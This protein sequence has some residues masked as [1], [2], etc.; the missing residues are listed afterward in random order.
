MKGYFRAPGAI[1]AA[2]LFM[3]DASAADA[4]IPFAEA[5]IP[6][7]ASRTTG[8]FPHRFDDSQAAREAACNRGRG[9]PR[10][11]REVL[12]SSPKRIVIHDFERSAW[13]NASSIAGYVTELL[14]AVPDSNVLQPAQLYSEAVASSAMG[15]MELESGAVRPIE[16]AYGYLHVAGESGCEWWG[17]YR[18]DSV[19]IEGHY[20]SALVDRDPQW[21]VNL[22]L[23]ENGSATYRLA[24]RSLG[25]VHERQLLSG[26]WSLKADLLTV[27]I[28]D[29]E[30][31]GKVTYKVAPCLS[32][33]VNTSV[34]CSPGV[35]PVSSSLG[36]RYF[37]PLWSVVPVTRPGS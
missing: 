27:D 31:M 36:D 22:D 8:D 33:E 1:L 20:T 37:R 34:Q 21:I 7:L 9:S 18:R 4:S 14:D 32:F 23:R 16:F 30:P 15:L 6:A 13:P 12:G 3:A 17:R 5:R 25:K 26:S 2:A 29:G 11:L 19:R 10:T 35:E 24:F 28:P